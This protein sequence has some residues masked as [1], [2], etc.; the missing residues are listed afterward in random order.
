MN[1]A[2][3]TLEW[4]QEKYQEAAIKK[5]RFAY[6]PRQRA[7]WTKFADNLAATIVIIEDDEVDEYGLAL[8]AAESP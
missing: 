8:K 6:N 5:H 1:Q 4:L 7:F 2:Q 3:Q